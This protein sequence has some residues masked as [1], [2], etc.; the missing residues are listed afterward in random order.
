MFAGEFEYNLKSAYKIPRKINEQPAPPGTTDIPLSTSNEDHIISPLAVL[1]STQ[2]AG[3]AS[4][5]VDK[6]LLSTPPP[7]P[8]PPLPTDTKSAPKIA[9]RK[10]PHGMTWNVSVR[11]AHSM[12]PLWKCFIR[13]FSCSFGSSRRFTGWADKTNATTE[14]C[15]LLGEIEFN[16]YGQYT[17]R[18]Q[19]TRKKGHFMAEWLV[20][21]YWR[22]AAK[23]LTSKRRSHW[24][25]CNALWSLWFGLNFHTTCKATLPGEKAST[26]STFQLLICRVEYKLSIWLLLSFARVMAGRAKPSGS[27]YFDAN[28]KWIR[29]WVVKHIHIVYEALTDTPLKISIVI[30]KRERILPIDSSLGRRSW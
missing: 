24:S 26:V 10:R 23:A 20:G 17:L 18:V 3:F 6:L 5:S 12:N 27:G 13:K 9:T 22:T 30:Q 29:V 11:N 15:S 2:T 8:P 14:L 25:K 7:P 28:N 1:S 21:S 16:Y 19:D 4:F